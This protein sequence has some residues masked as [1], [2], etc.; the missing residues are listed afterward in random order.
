MKK[1]LCLILGILFLTCLSLW[2]SGI[3]QAHSAK[4]SHEMTSQKNISQKKVKYYELNLQGQ[5]VNTH[6]EGLDEVEVSFY[7]GKRKLG[8]SITSSHGSYHFHVVIPEKDWH[9]KNFYLEFKKNSFK[10]EKVLINKKEIV[11]IGNQFFYKKNLTL[12]R[13]IDASF[14]IATIIFIAVYVIISFELLHR[15]LA[16]MFGAAIILMVSYLLGSFD[17]HYHIISFEKAIESIDMNVIFLLMGMM[18]IVGVLKHTGIFQWFAYVSYK[19]ARGNVFILSVISAL[20][21][22]FTSAFLDN[23]TTML[24]YA[25]VL[26]EIAIA[27][28][29][30]PF[31]LLLPAIMASNI[32][33]TSTLI[34]DPPNILIGSYAKLSFIAF[35]K[36][37]ILPVIISLVFLFIYDFVFY[38]KEYKKAKVENVD[39]FIQKL[40]E[41][42]KITDMTLLQVGLLVM[43]IVIFFFLTHGLWHMEPSIPAMFGGTLLAIYGVLTHRVDLVELFEKEIEWATLL[44]FIFLFILVGAV[45]E[46]GLLSLVA[47]WVHNLSHNNLLLAISL[48]LWVSAI[49]SAF[50]DNIPFTATML[51]I[52]AYL[53]RTIPGAESGVLWWA[54]ALGA[55]FG[56]NGTMIGAS[57]NVVTVGI[58]ENVGYKITFLEFFKYA[59]PYMILT[60]LISNIYLALF[61]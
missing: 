34:G 2:S 11:G 6:K 9:K 32:G 59:F 53:T 60:I 24:L 1:S 33:G 37:L 45:E 44:F 8:S 56:G 15:T 12:K 43:I 48:I 36:N 27:L 47:D 31:T 4:T 19:I 14:W 17:I 55:C 46:V 26:I 5:V 39:E 58:A 54:L 61:Y 51:P 16:A 22:G 28:R 41:E 20:F 29:I 21:V 25:P 23:V 38:G 50:I 18:L 40:R 7:L 57:A 42:Y 52:V 13:Q 49:M 10:T 35:V 30:N 3:K